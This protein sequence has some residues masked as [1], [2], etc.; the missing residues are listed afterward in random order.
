[1]IPD[2]ISTIR[3]KCYVVKP[4]NDLDLAVWYFATISFN[5]LNSIFMSFFLPECMIG[6]P[7]SENLIF[8]SSI[9]IV[10]SFLN[11]FRLSHGSLK[12]SAKYF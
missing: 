1:M 5:S 3:S 10:G 12:V 9:F 8:I 6:A 4:S 11:S 7:V 2:E